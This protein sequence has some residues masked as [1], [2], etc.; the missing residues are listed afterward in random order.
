MFK[1]PVLLP[2]SGVF[3]NKDPIA[4]LQHCTYL[5]VRALLFIVVEMNYNTV[6]IVTVARRKI[7]SNI[8]FTADGNLFTSFARCGIKMNNECLFRYR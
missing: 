3:E 2:R 8:S 4:P 1:T 7:M 6:F 5:Y